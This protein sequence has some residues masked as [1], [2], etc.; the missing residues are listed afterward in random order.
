MMRIAFAIWQLCN[1]APAATAVFRARCRCT[2][3]AKGPTHVCDVAVFYARV[4]AQT[5]DPDIENPPDL[6]FE[7]VLCKTSWRKGAQSPKQMALL[8]SPPCR[9]GELDLSW[10]LSKHKVGQLGLSGTRVDGGLAAVLTR[11]ND[12]LRHW[13]AVLLCQGTVERGVVVDSSR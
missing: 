10:L 13:N 9:D 11:R 2:R 4:N 6:D 3:H 8:P 7:N 5:P 1:A 12:G